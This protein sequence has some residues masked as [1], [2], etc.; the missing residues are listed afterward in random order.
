MIFV[1]HVCPFQAED[2][3]RRERR[4][5]DWKRRNRERVKA[6][7]V[8]PKVYEFSRPPQVVQDR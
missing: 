5:Q 1:L 3:V 4:F 7:N 6:W 8:R 2:E